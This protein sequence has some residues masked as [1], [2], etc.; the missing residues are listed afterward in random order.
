MAEPQKGFVRFED[1]STAFFDPA[2]FDVDLPGGYDFDRAVRK[3]ITKLQAERNSRLQTID[4]PG[5]SGNTPP[6]VGT[7]EFEN[8][9][10]A[11]IDMRLYRD[12]DSKAFG[13][14]MREI[15]AQTEEAVGST[16]SKVIIPG[17]S[18]NVEPTVRPIRTLQSIGAAWRGGGPIF[19]DPMPES[20]FK[21]KA[22]MTG[23]MVGSLAEWLPIPALKAAQGA[24]RTLQGAGFLTRQANRAI[25]TGRRAAHVATRAPARSGFGAV[26]FKKLVTDPY[27]KM[28]TNSYGEEV[29]PDE[30][31]ALKTFAV[32]A[33]GE[34]LFGLPVASRRF[35]QR[36]YIAGANNH[37]ARAARQFLIDIGISQ[38]RLDQVVA[39][40]KGNSKIHESLYNWAARHPASGTAIDRASLQAQQEL[41]ENFE[42]R[43]VVFDDAGQALTPDIVRAGSALTRGM[44]R[45]SRGWREV[46]AARYSHFFRKLAERAPHEAPSEWTNTRA[47]L[48]NRASLDPILGAL[49]SDKMKGLHKAL[50]DHY[51]LTFRKNLLD[52]TPAVIERAQ[53]IPFDTLKQLRTR[54]GEK[55]GR[56]DPN[57]E[58]PKRQLMDLHEAITKDLEAAAKRY[59][60]ENEFAGANNY[61]RE[62]MEFQ[63]GIL[64]NIEK[65]VTNV[66]ASKAV[67]SLIRSGD[68]ESLRKIKTAVGANTNEWLEVQNYF[69]RE[70]GMNSDGVFDMGTLFGKYNRMNDGTKTALVGEGASRKFLDD[71][72]KAVEI[73]GKGFEKT[74]RS[75]FSRMTK[76]EVFGPTAPFAWGVFGAGA[77][78]TYSSG[79]YTPV[80]SAGVV[81][82][83][84]A[85]LAPKQAAKLLVDPKYTEWA[86]KAMDSQT[87]EILAGMVSRLG[88]QYLAADPEEQAI[89]NQYVG[90]IYSMIPKPGDFAGQKQGQ[91][92]GQAPE[93]QGQ[94]Q[95]PLSDLSLSYNSKGP[96]SG[97]R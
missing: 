45:F 23:E 66:D 30:E 91:G 86:V 41:A 16:R 7:I 13:S 37:E 35:I 18:G 85:Y 54:V 52:G 49:D 94:Q 95:G 69:I 8:G 14:K 92:Q 5:F 76:A 48:Q 50:E 38:P 51:V 15:I 27:Q 77:A 28:H 32:T 2:E 21:A 44:Q 26:L 31:S 80:I 61:W 40:A 19:G 25:N 59:G 88:T 58:I 60:L 33:A 72:A 43:W 10:T 1:G 47:F 63:E 29:I 90:H 96:F 97:G 36:L 74:N 11:T 56:W 20:K 3:R 65:K 67:Q 34:A 84:M 87:P 83:A 79:D 12:L 93:Q 57:S 22:D 78:G 9:K 70:L 64:E 39:V 73:F 17:F 6:E 24:Q 68:Y 46:G 55:I 82:G 75:A 81:L 4:I 71:Y 53:D 89:I 42:K 62:H